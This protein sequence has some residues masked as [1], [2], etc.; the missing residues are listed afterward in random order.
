MFALTDRR[1]DA[2]R[3]RYAE[4]GRHYH[5]QTHLDALLAHLAGLGKRVAAPAAVELAIWYHDA[6]Y[7]PLA[8]DNEA[9]SAALF[10]ADLGNWVAPDLTRDVAAMI[11]TTERRLLPETGSPE[12]LADCALFLDMDLS[13]LGTPP[14]VFAGYEAAI[15]KDYAAVPDA[16]HRSGRTGR[17]GAL[18]GTGPAL[19]QR[20]LPRPP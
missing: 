8:R 19:L 4:V 2:L 13:I 17:A 1:R 10:H 9:R 20:P 6:V 11:L 15:R 14:A 16:A 5:N 18:P 3:A 7:E 12:F